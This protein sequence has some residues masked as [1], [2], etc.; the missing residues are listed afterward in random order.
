M[1]KITHNEQTKT[2]RLI[3]KAGLPFLNACFCDGNVPCILTYWCAHIQVNTAV[4]PQCSNGLALCIYI[5]LSLNVAGYDAFQP[6]EAHVLIYATAPL[7]PLTTQPSM[8]TPSKQARFRS[9]K[10]AALHLAAGR[11]RN[12]DSV[13]QTQWSCFWLKWRWT[14]IRMLWYLPMLK[15]L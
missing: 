10:W 5:L 9:W 13:K 7:F 11:E 3:G 6:L 1:Q 14:H 12:R 8:S 2:A 15:C 4:F